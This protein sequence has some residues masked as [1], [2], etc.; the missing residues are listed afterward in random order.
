MTPNP[1]QSE[2]LDLASRLLV[3]IGRENVIPIASDRPDV[4]VIFDGKTVGIEVTQYHGNE[5]IIARSKGS[6]A[7]AQEVALA[8]SRP[9]QSYPSWGNADPNPALVARILDKIEKAADYDSSK[10]YELW[11][12]VA[13]GIPK[14][15]GITSTVLFPPYVN[16]TTLESVIGA[17]LQSSVFSAVYIHS[18]LPSALF[19]W[20]RSL[21]WHTLNATLGSNDA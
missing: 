8:R 2:E 4:N 15:G 16:L 3:A 1:K 10:Y 5:T 18:H 6:S 20:S 11:L 19:I 9:N 7:R 14:L 17:R 13:A 21:G 12:L